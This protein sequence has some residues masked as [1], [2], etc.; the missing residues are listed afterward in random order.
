MAFQDDIN[1]LNTQYF[2][3]ELTYSATNFTPEASSELELADSL[4]WLD[5]I[6]IAFQIKERSQD[7]ATSPETE[8]KWFSAKVLKHGTKQIRDTLTYL[9]EHSPITITNRRGHTRKIQ[10][11]SFKTLQKVVCFHPSPL[12]PVSCSN[13]RYHISSTAGVIH[14]ISSIDYL[15]IVR[16]LLTPAEVFDYLMFREK[17]VLEWKEVVREIS[18]QALVGQYLSSADPKIQPIMDSAS[19]LQQV[20][21][22]VDKWDISGVLDK[23]SEKIIA[24]NESDQYYP[25]IFEISKL[26]RNELSEFKMRYLLTIENSKKGIVQP[27][28]M[29][30]L[31]TDCAFIFIPVPADK[32]HQINNALMNLTLAGQYS[33]KAHRCVGVAVCQEDNGFYLANWCY[34]ESVRIINQLYQCG[35][36]CAA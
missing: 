5:D 26:K 33:L 17:L 25:I 22:E 36:V 7:A 1:E 9:Q 15:G 16:T 3:R 31:R 23:F 24:P 35:P 2:F 18:E 11:S 19:I 8:E 12:L 21:H 34:S 30:C 10:W 32:K 4:I 6:G 28:R 14:L 20:N 27:Y 13:M 29:R